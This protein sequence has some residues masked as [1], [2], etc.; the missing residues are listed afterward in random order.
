MPVMIRTALPVFVKVTTCAVL[1]VFSCWLEKV[2]L[3][4]ERLTA[5]P[6]VVTPVPV[7][8]MVW[9]LG[10]ALSVMAMAPVRVP[11]AAGVNVTLIVQF[12][13]ALTELPHVFV[14]T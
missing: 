3:G 8:L 12:A 2:R 5:G 7:R 9:G 11:V 4:A 1:G 6:V 14:C 10:V 13:P